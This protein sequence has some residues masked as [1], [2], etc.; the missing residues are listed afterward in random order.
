MNRLVCMP[1]SHARDSHR[2]K[3]SGR[4]RRSIFCPEQ[5]QSPPVSFLPFVFRVLQDRSTSIAISPLIALHRTAP[6]WIHSP[7]LRVGARY[8]AF[9][10]I[11]RCLLATESL[12]FSARSIGGADT[13]TVRRRRRCDVLVLFC[14]IPY[15]S[16]PTF[17]CSGQ[18]CGSRWAPFNRP[19][20]RSRG[21]K[22]GE[23]QLEYSGCGEEWL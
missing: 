8:V 22:L 15:P 23:C 14:T 17:D 6:R 19:Q 16:A 5:F 9:L 10:Q 21:P 20:P 7:I 1:E 11:T 13:R 4:W 3:C 2:P 18:T 12:D